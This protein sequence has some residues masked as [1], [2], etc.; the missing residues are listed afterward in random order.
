MDKYRL[1]VESDQWSL[2]GQSD[3]LMIII[4][5]RL[6]VESC[7]PLVTQWSVVSRM[8]RGGLDNTSQDLLKSSYC[9]S[10]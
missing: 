5:Y 2:T 6:K 4:K 3:E 1:K 10:R 8:N 7:W 9:L